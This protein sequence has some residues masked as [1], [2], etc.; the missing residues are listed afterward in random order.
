ME[1]LVVLAGIAGLV[2]L[3]FCLGIVLKFI[4]G[5]WISIV[6][7]LFCVYVGLTYGWGGAIGGVLGFCVALA[8]NN[9]WHDTKL[10]LLVCDKLDQWFYFKDT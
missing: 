10:Y 5:W 8:A 4:W 1:L 6:A 7:V 2:L 9:E 3:Y